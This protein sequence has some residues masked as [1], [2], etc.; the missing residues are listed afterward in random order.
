MRNKEVEPRLINQID[1]STCGLLRQ[2]DSP[3]KS[4]IVV[5]IISADQREGILTIAFKGILH[6]PADFE[7]D[8]FLGWD[9]DTFEG[10]GILRDARSPLS[11][12]EH[13]KIAEL[14]AIAFTELADHVVQEALDDSLDGGPPLAG[15]V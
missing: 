10:L 1:G 6:E 4:L 7:L 12:L 14:Q 8:G 11:D 5:I 15:L 2:C 3:A 9:G 13:A